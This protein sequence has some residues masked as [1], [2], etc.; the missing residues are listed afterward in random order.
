MIGCG[1]D[2]AAAAREA[3]AS[4]GPTSGSVTLINSFVVRPERDATFRA[5]WQITSR[6][7][8]GQPGF[9]SLRLHRAVSADAP[10]RWVNVATWQSEDAYRAAHATE[11]FRRVVT[12]P[13]WEEFPSTPALFQLA[14][15]A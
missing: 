1:D 14:A 12:Q 11:E 3:A 6:Y 4:E 8:I 5:L 15:E 13:G 2:V 7:F 9:V 10:Y